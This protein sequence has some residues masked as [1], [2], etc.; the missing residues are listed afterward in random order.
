[1]ESMRPYE[2]IAKSGLK[3]THLIYRIQNGWVYNPKGS[4]KEIKRLYQKRWKDPD[5][6]A[7]PNMDYMLNFLLDHGGTEAV[8]AYYRNIRMKKADNDPQMIAKECGERRGN[9]EGLIGVAKK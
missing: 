2:N 6:K 1:M 3:N 5:F 8:G 4:E 7:D 9:T